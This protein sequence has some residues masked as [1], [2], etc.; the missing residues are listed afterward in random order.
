[1]TNDYK[2]SRRG[3]LGGALALAG[4]AATG[5]ISPRAMESYDESAARKIVPVV[6]NGMTL[7]QFADHAI[8]TYD[9]PSAVK[10]PVFN[11]AKTFQ[12]FKQEF[13]D[14]AKA[15]AYTDTLK[16]VNMITANAGDVLN[17]KPVELDIAT[18]AANWGPVLYDL[19]HARENPAS[20]KRATETFDAFLSHYDSQLR[21]NAQAGRK[22]DK[23]IGDIGSHQKTL[24]GL[25]QV[26]A[27]N[28]ELSAVIK[29]NLNAYTQNVSQ[30]GAYE[31]VIQLVNASEG[32]WNPVMLDSIDRIDYLHQALVNQGLRAQAKQTLDMSV[33]YDGTNTT[34]GKLLRAKV[35]DAKGYFSENS[36]NMLDKISRNDRDEFLEVVLKQRYNPRSGV[37]NISTD[38]FRG[39]Q[40]LL[41]EDLSRASQTPAN[42]LARV[43]SDVTEIIPGKSLVYFIAEDLRNVNLP[44]SLVGDKHDRAA[45]IDMIRDSTYAGLG[46]EAPKN[47]V[48]DKDTTRAVLRVG[49]TI[50]QGVGLYFG[51]RGHSA[52]RSGSSNSPVQGGQTTTP[53]VGNK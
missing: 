38:S 21:D 45:F 43:L 17:A 28:A 16:Q 18:H 50:A 33:N 52:N 4:T 42:T 5:C 22:F 44:D 48:G 14:E 13:N 30:L 51:L 8:R 9:K 26:K 27:K 31:S 29:D 19:K 40:L 53:G 6:L 46:F 24:E 47:F 39:L 12:L 35:N 41:D 1:M 3:F 32:K 23:S 10:A 2:I 49:W 25:R 15:L 34:I 20:E 36:D 37:R 11:Q 7:E